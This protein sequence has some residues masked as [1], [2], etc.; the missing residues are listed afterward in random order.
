[1]FRENT[2]HRQIDLFNNFTCMD[3]RLQNTLMDSWS[4]LFYELVFSQIDERPFAPLYSS[5]MGRPNFPVN[6]LLSL[7]FT[8]HLKNYTDEELLEQFRFNY[9]VMYAVGIRN[10]G[11]SYF[12]IRTLYEFRERIY[13][14]TEKHPEEEDLIFKQFNELTANF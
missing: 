4:P 6:I 8:K 10:I 3:E 2:S 9:Q 12:A 5:D 11:E 7:E 14:Y 13:M 1:M